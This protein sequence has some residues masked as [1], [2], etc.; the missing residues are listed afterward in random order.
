MNK[1]IFDKHLDQNAKELISHHLLLP[2]KPPKKSV[3]PFG[4][5]PLPR[6]NQTVDFT[7]VFKQFC[8]SSLFV[9]KEVI[10]C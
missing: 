1:I 7:E 10:T 6:N 2:P 3:P 8:F 5:I 9:K 4:L